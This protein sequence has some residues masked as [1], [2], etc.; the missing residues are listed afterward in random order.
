MTAERVRLPC[1]AAMWW[2][3]TKSDITI[4]APHLDLTRVGEELAEET[5]QVV[6]PPVVD[7]AHPLGHARVAAGPVADRE[8]DAEEVVDRARK[9]EQ[10]PQ[11]ARGSPPLTR[12]VDD[13]VD[14]H[15]LPAVEHLLEEPLRSVKCQ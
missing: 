2:L 15:P 4:E 8:L 6:H 13:G 3:P 14:H 7:P 10:P 1:S 11:P 12:P 9:P 5:P